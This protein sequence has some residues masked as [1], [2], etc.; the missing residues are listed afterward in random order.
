M[1]K[2]HGWGLSIVAAAHAK[3]GNYLLTWPQQ[4]IKEAFLLQVLC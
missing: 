1:K 2:A 3:M 4:D